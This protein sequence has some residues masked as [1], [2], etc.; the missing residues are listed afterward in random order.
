MNCYLNNCS[1]LTYLKHT[2]H[3]L[4]YSQYIILFKVWNQ[5]YYIISRNFNEDWENDCQLQGHEIG[6]YISELELAHMVGQPQHN[7]KF[8]F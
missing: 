1:D 2:L 6:E 4:L 5:R 7:Y 3:E 8:L